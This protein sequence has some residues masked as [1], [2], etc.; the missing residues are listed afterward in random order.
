[1]SSS[2]VNDTSK[3]KSNHKGRSNNEESEE[4]LYSAPTDTTESSVQ[5]SGED[6]EKGIQHNAQAAVK[7]DKVP[8]TLLITGST[9]IVKDESNATNAFEFTNAM[10][11]NST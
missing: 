10:T 2:S 6:T 8:T 9:D 3:E 1:M 11:H 5:K 7:Q 4:V